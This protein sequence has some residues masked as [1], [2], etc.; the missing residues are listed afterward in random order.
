MD[1]DIES[2][3]S[4]DCEHIAGLIPPYPLEALAPAEQALVDQHVAGCAE[5]RALLA[6][7]GAIAE[8]LLYTTPPVAAPPHLEA[9]LRRR[10]QEERAKQQGY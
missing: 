4:I 3:N 6:E 5:C 2:M 7:Y 10:L 1:P 9:D 8:G